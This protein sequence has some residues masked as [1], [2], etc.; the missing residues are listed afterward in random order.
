M[1][2]AYRQYFPS[3]QSTSCGEAY[4]DEEYEYT[5]VDSLERGSRFD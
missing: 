1:F 5:S 4:E 2:Q 3:L